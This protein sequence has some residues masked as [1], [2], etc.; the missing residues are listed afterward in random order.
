MSQVTSAEVPSGSGLSVR[1]MIN[2]VLAALMS[3]N[4][5]SSEPPNPVAGMAW[6]DTTAGDIKIRNAANT[7]WLLLSDMIGALEYDRAQALTAAQKAQA[8][9]NLGVFYE[10]GAGFYKLPGNRMIQW[11]ST[12][13]AVSASETVS[14]VFPLAFPSLPSTVL[15]F[16]GDWGQAVARSKFPVL[17]HPSAATGATFGWSG[18]SAGVSVRTNWIAIGGWE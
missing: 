14:I 8:L 6:F 7:A 4:S 10:N 17:Y 1:Q 3:N 13:T 11:G 16:N 2:A 18:V 5:G 15:A 9:A 12:A